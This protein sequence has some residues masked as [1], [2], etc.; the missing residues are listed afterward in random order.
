MFWRKRN[1]VESVEDKT[2]APTPVAAPQI[3]LVDFTEAITDQEEHDTVA[4][5]C[6]A[7]LSTSFDDATVKIKSIRRI[8]QDKE[9]CGVDCGKCPG[10]R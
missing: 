10:T 9:V 2:V 6:F 7:I 3:P 5:H 1:K 4:C 8:D